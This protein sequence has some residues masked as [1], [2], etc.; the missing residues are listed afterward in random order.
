MKIKICGIT[1][2]EDALAAAD[3]GADYLGFNFYPKSPRSIAELDCEKIADTLRA[4]HPRTTR[5]G[6]FVNH[7][8][9][10]IRRIVGRCGLNA[11]QLSGAEPPAA[12]A[13]LAADGIPAFKAVR[14]P[15]DESALAQY[16]QTGTAEATLLLDASKPGL[17]GGTGRT[18]DWDW[19]RG[20][21]ARHPV[22]LAG[23]LT[24][25]NVDA[26]IRA[27]QPWGVDTASGV[28]ESA[29][30]KD[31]RMMAAFVAAARRTDR[32]TGVRIEP[33][34]PADAAEILAI[35]LAAYQS[36]A[37]LCDDFSIPPLTQT[38]AELQNEFGAKRI[39]RAVS[40]GQVIGSVRADCKDGSCRIGRLI[41]RP[42][43]QNRG[44]GTRLLR[45]IEAEFPQAQRF[46]L[47]T[48][49]RSERNL[50]L[51]NKLGYR[52]FRREP[53]NERMMLVYLEKR[54]DGWKV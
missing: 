40:G 16:A 42:D 47:F 19:A 15:I 52:E 26:A 53:M 21:A 30:R 20:V 48:G 50:H 9:A 24:P 18:A 14:A 28:E 38:L 5:V 34:E 51:Y 13:A 49:E 10:D 36:E 45:A 32:E 29:G 27:V 23:G 1:N 35:Q 4:R 12:L 8:P 46:E 3:L 54:T 25:E 2:L 39:L 31:R 37:A 17:F 22:F 7:P 11:A 44:L 33:A 43:R 6:V 41:V